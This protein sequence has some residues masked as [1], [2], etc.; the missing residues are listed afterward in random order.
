MPVWCIVKNDMELHFTKKIIVFTDG[1][2]NPENGT[3]ATVY[4]PQCKENI[5]KGITDYLSVYTVA[6]YSIL[7]I[8]LVNTPESVK[9]IIIECHAYENKR[10]ILKEIFEKYQLKFTLE[11]ILGKA[12]RKTHVQLFSY[13]KDRS[14]RTNMKRIE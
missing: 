8:E 12:L 13:L 7:C 10:I 2:K 3:G 5:K 6:V 9:H 14:T 4:I 1:S 11:N